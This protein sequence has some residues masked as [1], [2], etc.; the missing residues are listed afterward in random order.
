[1]LI[2]GQVGVHVPI[3]ESDEQYNYK[4]SNKTED[5]PLKQISILKTGSYFGEL[6]LLNDSMRTATII[7]REECDFAVLYRKDFKE[8]LGDFI[9]ACRMLI[10]VC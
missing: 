7:C 6:A 1:M 10:I 3:K 8:I 9:T 2:R 4:A 5:I